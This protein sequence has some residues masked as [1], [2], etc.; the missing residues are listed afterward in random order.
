MI[1]FII[2]LY[3]TH[4]SERINFF[5]QYHNC[6][7]AV[8]EVIVVDDCSEVPIPYERFPSIKFARIEDSIEWNIPG[9]RNLG[10]H[11]ATKESLIFTDVDHLFPA[12]VSLSDKVSTLY[13]RLYL[14]KPR[15]PNQGVIGVRK[16]DFKGFDEDYSGHYGKT[17]KTMLF[18]HGSIA[19]SETSIVLLETFDAHDQVRDTTRNSAMFLK[20]FKQIKD[21]TYQVPKQLNFKWKSINGC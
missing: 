12:K 14:G 16:K 13:P 19:T 20:K 8:H 10:A 9:A 17:D 3:I 6:I 5:L 2:P 4:W 11:L 15:K 21:G 18:D 7:G 1:S